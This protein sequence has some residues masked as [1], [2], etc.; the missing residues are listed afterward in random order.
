MGFY[1]A[2]AGVNRGFEVTYICGPG[3]PEFRLVPGAKNL[4]I[5]STQEMLDRVRSHI[6]QGAILVM[7]AAPADYKPTHRS[8]T[9]LKK[10]ESPELQLTPNPDILKTIWAESTQRGMDM[11]LV[12][13]AAET[14]NAKEYALG[15]LKEKNLDLIFLNDL[16]SSDSGFG[17][18]TNQ[19]TVFRRDGSVDDWET[20]SKERLGHRIIDEIQTYLTRKEDRNAT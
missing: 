1:I 2:L 7:A 9:K 12:G 15:K 16:S 8:P 6:A 11:T 3:E 14:H 20:A 10:T 17:V 5:T 19:L 4:Q 18:D 13:F